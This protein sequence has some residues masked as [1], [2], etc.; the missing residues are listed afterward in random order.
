MD[1]E[2]GMTPLKRTVLCGVLLSI[3]LAAQGALVQISRTER[4]PLR[5]PLASLPTTLGEW[6]GKDEPVDPDIVERSQTSEYL[7]RAYESPK[8]PGLVMRLWV[9]YSREGTNLR[10]TPEI[11][12]PSAGRT[13]IESQT[14][15]LVVD[16]GNARPTPLTRLAYTRGDLVEHVGFWYY[17]FGEGKLENYVR[18]L[19]ITS[20]SAYGQATRGSSMTVET[21]YPGESDPDG[22]VLLEFAQVLLR[23]LEPILPVD[24]ANYYVP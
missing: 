21:F 18:R 5:R 8:H 15:E 3:G 22:E 14:R 7:N 13:K 11:C 2:T 6:I 19:P 9:N 12:L 23:G 24:R 1:W 10:H 17:I 20:R 16:P 4:P